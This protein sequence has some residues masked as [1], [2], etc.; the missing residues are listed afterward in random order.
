[1][2]KRV[3]N[4]KQKN[5]ILCCIAVVIACI[6]LFPIYWIVVSS[7][8]TNAEIFASPP[9]FLPKNSHLVITQNSL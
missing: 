8:K 5:I 2:K 6:M 9:T 3:F 7:F 4:E 1:M